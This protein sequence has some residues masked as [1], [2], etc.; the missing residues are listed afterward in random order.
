MDDAHRTE[1]ISE[2]QLYSVIRFLF[3]SSFYFSSG[4]FG[5]D[6]IVT[7]V[8]ILYRTTT[9][10]YKITLLYLEAS[11]W[12]FQLRREKFVVGRSRFIARLKIP[13]CNYR[14]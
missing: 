8:I 12:Y 6:R 11:A 13:C 4:A 14:Q 5:T 2:V 3:S 9:N 10:I 1:M 7:N